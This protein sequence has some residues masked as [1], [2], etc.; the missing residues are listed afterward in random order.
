MRISRDDFETLAAFQLFQRAGLC[1]SSSEARRL[2]MQGGAYV[3]ETKVKAFDQPAS[4]LL[5]PEGSLVRAG[6]KRYMR[7]V[8]KIV[9]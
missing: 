5:K 2:I 4:E 8:Y 3:D 9:Q 1:R 7:V 6:K